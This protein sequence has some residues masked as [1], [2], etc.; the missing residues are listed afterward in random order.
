MSPTQYVVKEVIKINAD[1]TNYPE[2]SDHVEQKICQQKLRK[3]LTSSTRFQNY[4]EADDYET[5]FEKADTYIVHM[6]LAWRHLKEANEK[7]TIV[8]KMLLRRELSTLTWKPNET[9]ATFVHRLQECV[10]SILEHIAKNDPEYCS[11]IG[12][13]KSVEIVA[14]RM[15]HTSKTKARAPKVRGTDQ[16]YH[17]EAGDKFCEWKGHDLSECRNKER[18]EANASQRQKRRGNP[19]CGGNMPGFQR[20]FHP[21]GLSQVPLNTGQS[22]TFESQLTE[23]FDQ[24]TAEDRDFPPMGVCDNSLVPMV[25]WSIAEDHAAACSDDQANHVDNAALR[26]QG[27]SLIMDSGASS[28]MTGDLSLLH[29]GEL[30]IQSNTTGKTAVFQDTLHVP[31]LLKSLL[32]ISQLAR[33]NPRAQVVFYDNAMDIVVGPDVSIQA[34]TTNNLYELDASVLLPSSADVVFAYLVVNEAPSIWNARLGHPPAAST[35]AILKATHGAPTPNTLPTTVIPMNGNGQANGG[36]QEESMALM[37]SMNIDAKPL[38]Q[39]TDLEWLSYFQHAMDHQDDRYAELEAKIRKTVVMNDKDMDADRRHDKWMH[40]YWECLEKMNMTDFDTQ[41]PK[42]A[43]KAL[44]EGIRP[45]GLR[46]LVQQALAHDMR[47]LRNDVLA[48]FN[49]VRVELRNALKFMRNTVAA[50]NAGRDQLKPVVKADATASAKFTPKYPPK[51]KVLKSDKAPAAQHKVGPTKKKPV[52]WHCS[53]GHRVEDCPTASAAEKTAIVARKKAEWAAKLADGRT[54]GKAV[55]SLRDR[56]HGAMDST[57]MVTIPGVP[58]LGAFPALCDSGSDPVAL[59]FRGLLEF[60]ELDGQLDLNLVV[61]EKET[62]MLGFGSVHVTVHRRLVLPVVDIDTPKGPLSLI[63]VHA[64]VEEEEL[65]CTIT[66]GRPIMA[67]LGYDLDKMLVAARAK[68]ATW[69]IHALGINGDREPSAYQ[70][71]LRLR[72]ETDAI[73]TDGDE[74]DDDV[75]NALAPTDAEEKVRKILAAKVLVAREKGLTAQ[76]GETLTALLSEYT[77][78]FR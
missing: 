53:Q 73:D 52:C 74:S 21:H 77:D 70:K 7:T 35:Q 2:R 64:W 41:H 60:L 14:Y 75:P 46:E 38:D 29:N 47:Y 48:F 8:N 69:D 13:I 12:V 5:D 76:G 23:D 17:T 58:D 59:V 51:S 31:T 40:D 50:D 57:C 6:N 1:G 56:S 15:A 26:L 43:V 71:S 4:D 61:C 44:V 20:D 36:V 18:D 34:V 45:S 25:T 49:F 9:Y 66:F 24:S 39:I 72:D 37:T 19:W 32:S 54:D 28:H 10:D 16:V 27:P 67:E 30:R 62:S 3:Y 11:L 33:S 65:S 68:C 63:N 78:V 55:K 42:D 22:E